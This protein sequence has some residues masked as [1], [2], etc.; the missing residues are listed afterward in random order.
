MNHKSW[1]KKDGIQYDALCVASIFQYSYA[2][3]SDKSREHAVTTLYS[4][5]DSQQPFLIAFLDCPAQL[6]LG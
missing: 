5:D 4:N 6:F 1:P 3:R 2:T